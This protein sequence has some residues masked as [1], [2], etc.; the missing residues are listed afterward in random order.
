LEDLISD[1]TMEDERG[2]TASDVTPTSVNGEMFWSVVSIFVGTN[3]AIDMWNNHVRRSN[4]GILRKLGLREHRDMPT[5][6]RLHRIAR[7]SYNDEVA[8]R[9]EDPG[10]SQIL[11]SAREG[12]IDSTDVEVV[13]L[14][15]Q[16]KLAC[17]VSIAQ[18][19]ALVTRAQDAGTST[20]MTNSQVNSLVYGNTYDQ[21]KSL[22]V[23]NKA[24][25][26]QP[27]LFK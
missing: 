1:Q 23:L 9:M 19:T 27:P 18:R 8:V 26:E 2:I 22:L 7:D 14:K 10:L 17:T 12:N 3:R 5:N 4:N 24:T 15:L 20:L 25:Y 16:S 13:P 6:T 11:L 21:Q